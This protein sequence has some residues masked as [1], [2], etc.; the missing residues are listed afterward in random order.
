MILGGLGVW[1]REGRVWGD[2]VGF[3]VS[4]FYLGG[5]KCEGFVGFLGG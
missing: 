2:D 4:E 3:R 5:V 1:G